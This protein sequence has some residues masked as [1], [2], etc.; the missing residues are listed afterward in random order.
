M[1]KEFIKS[2]SPPILLDIYYGIR[3]KLIYLKYRKY[4]IKNKSLKDSMVGQRCFILGSGHSID[5]VDIN[6]FKNENI[7]GLNSFMFHNDYKAIMNSDNHGIKQHVFTPLH[8]F[9]S[10]NV[11]NVYINEL[12]ENIIDN[13]QCFFA[14][15]DFKHNYI[16]EFT[17]RNT[18]H[19]SNRHY[20][21]SNTPFDKQK[22]LSELSY[23]C[24]KT[25]WS[26]KTSSNLA[27]FL[28]LY[29]GFE[30]IYLLGVDHDHMNASPDN[31]KAVKGGVLAAAETR[32]MKKIHSELES[33]LD[34]KLE[35][36]EPQTGHFKDL[37]EV[38]RPMELIEE[39]F[40]LKVKNLSKRS[41]FYC[42]QTVDIE[43]LDI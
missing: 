18:V 20:I 34:S 4:F 33:K 10:L 24:S 42:H 36:R 14:I 13:I 7:I 11:H 23:D 1:L 8:E 31:I 37:I 3:F 29:M 2:L 35:I 6:R 28:A 30:Y 40:P 32:K 22:I 12:D 43:S 38:I 15:D 27:L 17:S 19:K 26:H 16:D 39:K 9:E 21:H 5:S 41:V 25:I